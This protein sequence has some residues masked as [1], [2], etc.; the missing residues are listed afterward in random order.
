[1]VQKISSS[2]SRVTPTTEANSKRK[3]VSVIFFYADSKSFKTIFG[4]FLNDTYPN[5]FLEIILVEIRY[6]H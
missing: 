3:R 5:G 2:G 6:T 4:L 1:M